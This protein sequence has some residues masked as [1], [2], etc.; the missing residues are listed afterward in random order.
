MTATAK[1]PASSAGPSLN[2]MRARMLNV[3]RDALRNVAAGKS[4]EVGR[5][6]YM[7]LVRWGAIR[8]GALTEIGAALLSSSVSEQKS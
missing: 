7:T 5:S 8:N 6:A 4:A 3:H 1:A 2:Q